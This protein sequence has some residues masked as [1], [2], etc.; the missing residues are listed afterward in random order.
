MRN[1]S[2]FEGKCRGKRAFE[3]HSAVNI[4]DFQ[5][6]ILPGHSITASSL[7]I[8]IFDVTVITVPIMVRLRIYWIT[9]DT[10]VLPDFIKFFQ[11]RVSM[12]HVFFC[13]REIQLMSYICFL[14]CKV[15]YMTTTRRL[16]YKINYPN[17]F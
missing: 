2:Y 11:Y 8:Q 5:K 14:K 7:R 12:D 15:L 3:S 13:I 10:Q 4:C 17:N 6:H 9:Y 1:I 16:Q